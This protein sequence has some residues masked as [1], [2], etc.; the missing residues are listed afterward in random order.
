VAKT[1]IYRHWAD[2][3][4]VLRAAVEA[5]VPAAIAP[6]T[7]S[8]RGD[9]AHFAGDLCRILATPPTSALIPGL[10]D[11]AERDGGLARLLA[12]FTTGRRRPVHEAVQRAVERGELAENVDPELVAGLLLGPLFYRRLL[13][14]EPL[15]DEFRAV[16]VETVLAVSGRRQC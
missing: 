14:R 9:L 7:G 8:L 11:A 12:Q 3:D 16:L 2:K 4:A 13:S 10:I 6:D 1:T 15:D 5:I